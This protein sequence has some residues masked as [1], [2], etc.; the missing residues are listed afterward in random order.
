MEENWKK[1]ERGQLE[2]EQGGED[3]GGGQCWE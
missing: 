3:W 1:A 2:E